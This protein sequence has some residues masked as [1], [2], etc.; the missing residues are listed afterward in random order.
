MA[1][2]H[3]QLNWTRH[4]PLEQAKM[5]LWQSDPPEKEHCVGSAN[6]ASVYTVLNLSFRCTLHKGKGS[7]AICANERRTQPR[8]MMAPLTKWET[9]PFARD[10]TEPFPIFYWNCRLF[11]RVKLLFAKWNVNYASSQSLAYK[12]RRGESERERGR[13]RQKATWRGDKIHRHWSEAVKC[14]AQQ[15]QADNGRCRQAEYTSF[16]DSITDWYVLSRWCSLPSNWRALSACQLRYFCARR[17]IFLP[18]ERANRPNRG[19]WRYVPP[20]PTTFRQ[21]KASLQME[22][23]MEMVLL[24]KLTPFPILTLAALYGAQSCTLINSFK[25]QS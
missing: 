12:E 3:D 17:Q 22:I 16:G 14:L 4:W 10:T 24:C 13:E 9:L 21:R 19:N 6:A 23:E 8:E 25:R 15:L 1:K 11:C 2:Q 5:H 20:A 18:K 7:L